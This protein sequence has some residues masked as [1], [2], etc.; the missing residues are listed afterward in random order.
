MTTR[1]THKEGTD[2]RRVEPEFSPTGETSVEQPLPEDSQQT[3]TPEGTDTAELE[4]NPDGMLAFWQ[5]LR[6]IG[7]LHRDGYRLLHG[8][9]IRVDAPR[10]TRGLWWCE[11]WYWSAPYGEMRRAAG[12]GYERDAAVFKGLRNWRQGRSSRFIIPGSRVDETDD[13]E[14]YEDTPTFTR[15]YTRRLHP[16]RIGAYR[17]MGV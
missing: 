11:L 13:Q 9:L 8:A 10:W 6:T 4:A 7:E 17:V 15:S 5:A 1:T 16:A 2:R 12:W 3:V 14:V